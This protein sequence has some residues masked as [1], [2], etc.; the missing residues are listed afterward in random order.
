ME[1]IGEFK[2]LLN[3][4]KFIFFVLFLFLVGQLVYSFIFPSNDFTGTGHQWLSLSELISH[5]RSPLG[6]SDIS[7]IN[8]FYPIFSNYILNAD[9]GEYIVLAEDFPGYYFKNTIYAARPLYSFLIAV[10]AFLPRLFFDSFAT[11]FASAIFLNFILVLGI[12]FLLYIFVEKFISSRVAFLSSFLFIV[13]FFVHS[14]IIQ[15]LPEMLGAF[16]IITSLYLLYSY[17]KKPS[18]PKLII[19]SLII[20]SFMLAKMFF[21]PTVFIL[22]LSIYFRRFKE[23][24]IFLLIHLMPLLLWYLTV[25]RVFKLDYFVNE[26]VYF[27]AGI[28]LLNIFVLPWQ[29]TFQIFL[30]ILPK[31]VTAVIHGFLLIPVIFAIV[32]FKRFYIANKNILCFGFLFSFLTVFFVANFYLPR[33]AF[34]L[35][36]LVYPLAVLGIDSTAEFFKKYKTWYSTIFYLIT[37]LLIII[38]SSLNIYKI[39]SY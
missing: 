5:K 4:R 29:Q 14:S 2:N 34:L 26:I 22:I 28:W 36:P 6:S 35:F 13:S 17:V 38:I 8:K 15:P 27:D 7:I 39:I 3:K 25:T 11:V 31:F 1:I 33:H 18:Y 37:Y 19:F 23:G 24:M 21:V 9:G 16:I 30:N 10:V 12:V 32:G 20:G